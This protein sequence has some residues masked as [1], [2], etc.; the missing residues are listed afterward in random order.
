MKNN[1]QRRFEELVKKGADYYSKKEYDKA[2]K[3]FTQAIELDKSFLPK[4]RVS[5]EVLAEAYYN[6]GRAKYYLK[7]YK[8]A[9]ADHNKAIELKPDYAKAYYKRGNVKRKLKDYQGAI[10]DFDKAIELDR[11]YAKAYHMKGVVKYNLKDYEEAIKDFEEALKLQPDNLF[12]RGNL[13]IVKDALKSK[14]TR[15]LIEKQA[16]EQ[17]KPLGRIFKKTRKT[18]GRTK[19]PLGKI[20]RKIKRYF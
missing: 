20:F 1:E 11:D 12:F 10:A 14:E 5:K 15:E 9:I 16:E 8:G 17:K 3:C 18:S 6:R 13:R 19:K 7:D 2:I 4:D